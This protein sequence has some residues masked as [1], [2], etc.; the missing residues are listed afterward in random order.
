MDDKWSVA[1]L[2][3][4]RWHKFVINRR[5]WVND[6]TAFGAMTKLLPDDAYRGVVK[7]RREQLRVIRGD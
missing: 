2:S 5:G 1:R 4:G 6:E 3:Q 7:L